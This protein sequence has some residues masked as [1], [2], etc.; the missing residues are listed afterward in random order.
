MNHRQV[1]SQP[2]YKAIASGPAEVEHFFIGIVASSIH[3][4][5]FLF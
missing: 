2:N 5:K 1:T 3:S 4:K